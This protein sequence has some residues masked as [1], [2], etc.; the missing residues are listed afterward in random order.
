MS[1]ETFR[2]TV[3]RVFFCNPDGPF[4]TGI[5]DTDAGEVRFAGKVAANEGD[6]LEIVGKWGNHPKYG[7]QV[8]VE[9]GMV[10]MD[11]SPDALAHLLAKHE[12]F[13][14]IGAARARAIVDAAL[15]VSTDGEATTAIVEHPTAVAERAGVS[16]EIVKS[17][18]KVW[19]DRRDYFDALTAL[20]DQGWSNAQAARIVNRFGESAP[21][22][23]RDD[24]YQVIGKLARFGF[25]TVDAVARNM[26]VKSTDP[27]RLRA[28]LAYCLDRIAE[29]GNTWTTRDGLLDEAREEL[30]PD[31]LDG[32]DKIR[33]TLEALI[34]GGHVLCDQSPTDREIVA[35]ARL[36]RTEIAV[37]ERLLDGLKDESLPVL[38]LN[39][40][41]AREVVPTLNDGQASALSGFSRRKVS[42]MSGGAGV[43]KT[44]TTKA[45]CDVAEENRLRIA[46]CAPTGKAA[47]KLE[48]ATDRRATTIHKL[49]APIFD[50]E[51]GGFTFTRNADRPLELDLLIV[52]E[53]SM[54]DVRLMRSLLDALP[55]TCRILL[56]GDH[57]QIPSVGPGAILRDLL[58]AR[59]SYPEAV[60]VL[61]DIVRQ[62]GP[63]ARN[64]T[65]LL[66]GVVVTE[67]LP[68]W[69]LQRTERGNEEGASSTVAML[70][71]SIVSAPGP[72]EP[73]GR[74]L[75]IDWD[76]QVLAPMR[77]G[78]LGTYA[79]NVQL[80]RLRQ[81]LLGNPPPELT[82]AN[83][84]PKPLA[85][86]KVIWTKNDYELD[87]LNGT[88]AIVTGFKKGGAIDIFTEDGRE[89]TIEGAKRSNLEVAWAIT[90]HKS[91]GSEWPM[92]ILAASSS[93][94]IMH[95][96]NLLYTGTSRAAESVTI[97]GDMAGIK[98]F[99]S[100]RRSAT[101]QT[102][103]GFLVHGWRPMRLPQAVVVAV[104]HSTSEPE[105]E[106][107]AS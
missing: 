90:I 97:L 41:R 52:D 16:L 40:A 85:G 34:A 1:N 24:P 89:V 65:A 36:A 53:F 18:A 93:H 22:L 5:L 21:A 39:G 23:L 77:K 105:I 104:D 17:A 66:D 58:A 2:G 101:R 100:E 103:G 76:V 20:V 54:C 12:D 44:Y 98:S 68:A 13:K 51:A 61:T 3:R 87:L 64:T 32:E 37:F 29:N 82:P 59:N 67:E 94:R 107:N 72:L 57:H 99:A 106:A 50:P 102:F 27:A 88:Q 60:H 92:V 14:G 31:T 4:T 47:R 15:T 79:L 62:A 42:V 45:V 96:R 33:D 46:L 38:S 10:Q 43:G 95:D 6:K 8:E 35:D 48:H 11:E 55:A 63:L 91:Q 83:K 74:H 70:V 75:D 69:G 25:R 71:E 84:P 7:R 73:F 78:P 49:L 81:R 26:G 30:R 28:G 86:D 80:Q 19:A 9:T 56:V